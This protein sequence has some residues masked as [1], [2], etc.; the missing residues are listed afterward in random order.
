MDKKIK[1]FP[2]CSE[3]NTIYLYKGNDKLGSSI[4]EGEGEKIHKKILRGSAKNS[5]STENFLKLFLNYF[6][7]SITRERGCLYI[8]YKRERERE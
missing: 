1:Q 4:D 7:L 8:S 2:N 3:S 5:T 6:C